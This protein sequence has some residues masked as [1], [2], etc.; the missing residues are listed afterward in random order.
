VFLRW[1]LHC[2][3][4]LRKHLVAAVD[5]LPRRVQTLLL[6]R[7]QANLQHLQKKAKQVHAVDAAVDVTLKP[8][9]QTVMQS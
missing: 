6:T 9:S 7:L 8:P 2:R 5:A 1:H 3:P 4:A